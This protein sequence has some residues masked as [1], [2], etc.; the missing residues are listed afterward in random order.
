MPLI[1]GL[2]DGVW[3]KG[4]CL[5]H[6]PSPAHVGTTGRQFLVV[7]GIIC[8]DAEHERATIAQPDG[9]DHVPHLLH[10]IAQRVPVVIHQG[11]AVENLEKAFAIHHGQ[12]IGPDGPDEI[13]VVNVRH[14]ATLQPFALLEDGVDVVLHDF[15]DTF[16]MLRLHVFGNVGGIDVDGFTLK[17]IADFLGPHHQEAARILETG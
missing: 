5:D 4:I 13:R 15:N 12:F 6:H 1:H 2:E 11:V 10:S 3:I 7:M 14:D 17:P 16:A 9:I 8:T